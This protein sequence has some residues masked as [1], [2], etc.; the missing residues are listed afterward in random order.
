MWHK[1]TWQR[2]WSRVHHVRV[3]ILRSVWVHH[4][5]RRLESVSKSVAY[6]LGRVS[7]TLAIGVNIVFTMPTKTHN[8]CCTLIYEPIEVH[9]AFYIMA[10][11]TVS[12]SIADEYYIPD[13][14]L[15]ESSFNADSKEGRTSLTPCALRCVITARAVSS[16]AWN[17]MMMM[18][19]MM[20]NAT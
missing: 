17:M 13:L 5:Y 10:H 20:M 7:F 8:R 11:V 14:V 9:L 1:N 3:H 16:V 2:K 19:M 18:M 12:L 15:H 4:A 6:G